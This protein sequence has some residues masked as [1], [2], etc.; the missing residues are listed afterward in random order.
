MKEFVSNSWIIFVKKKQQLES[1]V[2]LL[3]QNGDFQWAKTMIDKIAVLETHKQKSQSMLLLRDDTYRDSLLIDDPIYQEAVEHNNIDIIQLFKTRQ[4]TQEQYEHIRE[5]QYERLYR[6][7]EWDKEDTPKEKISRIEKIYKVENILSMLDIIQKRFGEERKD[8]IA[9]QIMDFIDSDKKPTDFDLQ[10]LEKIEK[11]VRHY[12][13][14]MRKLQ[15][16][17]LR[18][19][20]TYIQPTQVQAIETIESHAIPRQTREEMITTKRRNLIVEMNTISDDMVGKQKALYGVLEYMC[21]NTY[22]P[23]LFFDVAWKRKDMSIM[24]EFAKLRM[25][26]AM[27]DGLPHSLPRE[28]IEYVQKYGRADVQKSFDTAYWLVDKIKQLRIQ[29]DERYKKLL[30]IEDGQKEEQAYISDSS[31]V[32][33]WNLIPIP[34]NKLSFEWIVGLPPGYFIIQDSE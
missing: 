26:P 19:V 17:I 6:D 11:R 24:S 12:L 27:E 25:L 10:Y 14:L 8:M 9:M 1:D 20:E 21:R 4:L 18:W 13:V 5:Q 32:F 16:N 15:S 30:A 3:L 2:Q 31:Q 23:E 33:V 28:F 29:I 34:I 22:N 7:K